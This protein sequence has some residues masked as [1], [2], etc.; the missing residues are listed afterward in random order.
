MGIF[1]S[2]NER[3]LLLHIPDSSKAKVQELLGGVQ[4]YIVIHPASRWR[5][6]CLPPKTVAAVI[7]TLL[8]RG[9]KVV[10]TSGPDEVEREMVRTILQHC[11]P[12]EV[13]D[14][15]GRISLKDLAAVIDFAKILIC[16]DSVPLHIASATKT[17]VV[18]AFG[19][20]SELN[21][22]PWMHPK[23]EVVSLEMSCRPCYKDGC[24]GSKM[25]DCLFSMPSSQIMK[26]VDRLLQ[27]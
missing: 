21:W 15:G 23:S 24:A 4:S 9:E 26:S 25:S 6:K 2:L 17:P 22:G 5:Y 11:P 20:S 10:L 1:P 8:Q 12:G 16:V 14:L 19:P 7:N 13:I 27:L 18:V 3:D